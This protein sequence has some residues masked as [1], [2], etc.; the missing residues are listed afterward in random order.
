M[1]EN[2]AIVRTILKNCEEKLLAIYYSDEKE[3]ELVKY[4]NANLLL[5]EKSKREEKSKYYDRYKIRYEQPYG[6]KLDYNNHKID[7]ADYQSIQLVSKDIT[8]M[9]QQIYYLRKT[10]AIILD[11][12]D[13]ALIEI[14]K[15]FYNENPDFSSKD[16]NIKFQT[17][18]CIL[19]EFGIDLGYG[20]F[21]SGKEKIPISVDLKE[22]VDK[23]YPLGEVSDMED[24]IKL[25]EEAKKVIKIVGGCIRE[26]IP[27]EQSLNESLIKISKIL[28]PGRCWV[29]SR[30]AIEIL[31][32]VTEQTP[33]E[34]DSF[35]K[36]VKRIDTKIDNK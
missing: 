6:I 34:V 15:L 30:K 18:M 11:K 25:A 13:K 24:S 23:L 4:D 12:D 2:V 27:N 36:L 7:L 3:E 26:S 16:I 35:I 8:E 17:M 20:F 21:P 14:Y 28:Q 22:R 5:Y 29:S 32:R 9:M 31:S 10:K 1:I 19:A 33:D